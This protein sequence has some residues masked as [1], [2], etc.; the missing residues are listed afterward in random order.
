MSKAGYEAAKTAIENAKSNYLHD[1][2]YAAMLAMKEN[3]KE[4]IRVFSQI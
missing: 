4:A 3:V 1:V 2:E